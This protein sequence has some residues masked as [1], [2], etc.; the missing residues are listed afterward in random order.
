MRERYPSA[1]WTTAVV[2]LVTLAWGA[3]RLA[4][5]REDF[6]PITFV[7]P[8]LVCVWTRRAWQLWAMAAAFLA[9]LL[10]KVVWILPPG[11][12]HAPHLA[13][14]FAAAVFNVLVGAIVVHLI[15]RLRDRLDADRER[16]LQQNARLEAQAEDL[17]QQNEEIKAQT[18]EL[19][20]QNSEIETQ[21]EELERQNQELHEANERLASR[22]EVLQ[23]AVESTRHAGGAR[24]ALQ[25]VCERM[26]RVVGAPA[27]VVAVLELEGG[28]LRRQ[29]EA[30][31]QPGEGLPEEWPLE[32]SLAQV[33]LQKDQ[34]AYV[35]DLQR[36]P[37]LSA[38]FDQAG[39]FRSALAT[40][41][42]LRGRN[43]GI[44]VVCSRQPAHWT[45]EQFRLVEWTA[46]QAAPLLESLRWQEDL[47]TRTATVEA[48]NRAKDDFLAM[49]SH[50]LRTPLTPV[51][52]AAGALEQDDRLPADVRAELAMIR[53]NVAVQSRLIDDLLDLT[54]IGR[55]KLDLNLQLVPV[56]ALLKDAAA[57][58]SADVDAR[59]QQLVID[60]NLPP[61]CAV[62]GDG[63]RLQQV[64]WNVLKNAL[65]FSPR[66]GR[67]EL[68]AEVQSVDPALDGDGPRTLI[69]RI[70]DHGVGIDR[71]D[72]ERIFQP[73]EQAGPMRG[74]GS[75]AGGLGLGLSIARAIVQLH[76][77]TLTADSDGLGH[78]ATFTI[79]LPLTSDPAAAGVPAP[80]PE[81][82][83]A[84][85]G[86]D[87][88][89]LR[90]LLVEDHRDTG[91]VISRLLRRYGYDVVH[92]MS[93]TEA[94]DACAT[95]SF[96]LLVSDLGLPDG[97][98][99]QLIGRLR[100][101]G[102]P[103]IRGI[104]M[105]GFGMESDIEAS[106]AAGFE[107]HLIKPIDMQQLHAAVR[108]VSA[109]LAG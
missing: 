52:A 27:D 97:S 37:D 77:G 98:G 2:A 40:P 59:D 42:R 84:S 90:I 38:P 88:A 109:P 17:V 7:L 19:I 81:P 104:C 43:A 22:E 60:A 105:S 24:L 8:L 49:L 102:H 99:L 5:S 29:V 103:T 107:E 58:V 69:V 67:V 30:G 61:G 95:Q 57:I 34:T 53:R 39:R 41:V 101:E 93:V 74:Q 87:G 68:S 11:A 72:L 6:F 55:G 10:A 54:R 26:L 63:A 94:V 62:V 78:G 86:R 28:H 108:R 56:A 16:I 65:K 51:L 18:E 9:M 96:D 46:A 23:A 70:R 35:D 75:G 47:Q 31:A 100:R 36:R 83:A 15:L 25:D 85:T 14:G 106:R 21:A 3:L 71:A 64:F 13:F 76:R 44:L 20:Q 12:L 48:L 33:V 82:A 32:G 50:E 89:P 1:G 73:F 80:V 92:A 4:V 91:M 79:E 45:Q 66:G